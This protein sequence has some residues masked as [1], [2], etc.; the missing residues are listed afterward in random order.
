MEASAPSNPMRPG[1]SHGAH[2]AVLQTAPVLRRTEEVLERQLGE[3]ATVGNPFLVRN[4]QGIQKE[5]F[6]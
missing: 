3:P 4:F 6:L 5:K 2:P 1:D